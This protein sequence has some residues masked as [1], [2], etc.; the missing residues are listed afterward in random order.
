MTASGA[1]YSKYVV[2]EYIENKKFQKEVVA[3]NPWVY[4]IVPNHVIKKYV[5]D[6]NLVK[7][8]LKLKKEKRYTHPL[9]FKSD[10]NIKRWFYIKAA[11]FNQIRKFRKY[12]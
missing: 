4:T 11:Y 8:Y 1:N 3:Y 7:E 2:D 5:S 10:I 9:Y 12:F 6:K